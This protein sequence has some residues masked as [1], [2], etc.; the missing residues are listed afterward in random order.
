[1]KFNTYICIIFPWNLLCPFWRL[2]IGRSMTVSSVSYDKWWNFDKIGTFKI[3]EFCISTL[4]CIYKGSVV[5]LEKRDI[6]KVA[7]RLYSKTRI[8]H[9]NTIS[10]CLFVNFFHLEYFFQRLYKLTRPT[11]KWLS[12]SDRHKGGAIFVEA[13][14]PYPNDTN[15]SAYPVD[16]SYSNPTF[17]KEE[18]SNST[19]RL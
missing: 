17:Q 11:K 2:S 5:F 19:T 16:N 3:N 9:I 4:Q 15:G 1:M 14:P 10:I 12:I 18:M 7:F 8:P 13:P 6:K